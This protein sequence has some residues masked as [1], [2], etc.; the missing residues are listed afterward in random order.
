ML[1]GWCLHFEQ[2]LYRKP[3]QEAA[4]GS[5]R[6]L[7][8]RQPFCL[9]WTTRHLETGQNCG[10]TDLVLPSTYID[11]N[12][13]NNNNT[14][15]FL[16]WYFLGSPVK[17]WVGKWRVFS[18][19]DS[20]INLKNKCKRPFPHPHHQC[21]KCQHMWQKR[22]KSSNDRCKSWKIGKE[23]LR[24]PEKARFLHGITGV[25][26][27][28]FLSLSSLC[29]VWD[30]LQCEMSQII[31]SSCSLVAKLSFHESNKCLLK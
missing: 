31:F 27:T 16:C 24:S 26:W 5:S 23:M 17:A 22:K 7:S 11:I 1:Q 14:A 30:S 15:S 13:N 9:G 28:N 4:V 29:L 8:H 2:H 12:N 10:W 6:W 3:L 20:G 25:L 21:R 18:K 19:S